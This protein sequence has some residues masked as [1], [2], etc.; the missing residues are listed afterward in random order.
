MPGEKQSADVE[1]TEQAQK[2]MEATQD[3]AHLHPGSQLQI[4]E[5]MKAPKPWPKEDREKWQ[6]VNQQDLATNLETTWRF[7]KV[8]QG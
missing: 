2:Q 4:R 1:M 7:L 6:I 3:N 8:L 5:Q